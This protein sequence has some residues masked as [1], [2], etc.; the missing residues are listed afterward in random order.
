MA[1]EFQHKSKL[2]EF[3]NLPEGTLCQLIDGEIIMSPSPTFYHQFVVNKILHLLNQHASERDTGYVIPSPIDVY[4]SEEE[5]FQPDIIFISRERK[6]IIKEKIKGVPDLV[7]EV[8]S[9]STAYYDLVHKKNIYEESDVK[10]FWVVD[11]DEKSFEVYEN[12]DKKFVI[13]SKARNGG[14]VESKLLKDLKIDI[15]KLFER[16]I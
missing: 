1:L 10:E 2:Q 11:T 7:V 6:D 5:V 4:F 13:Y 9:P 15:K 14:I 3:E 16:V 8:L 12:T